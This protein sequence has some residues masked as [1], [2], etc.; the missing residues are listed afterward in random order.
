MAAP[1]ISNVT[2]VAASAI[3]ATQVLGLD[4]T[5]SVAIR[6]AMLVAYFPNL[7][8]REV[9]HDGTSFGPNYPAASGNSRTVISGG[10]R[11][12]LLRTG[13]WPA[14]PTIIPYVVDVAGE[15]NP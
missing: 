4:A 5:A 3:A 14:S 11:Y 12:T 10:F 2:P 9:I 7:G 6:L 1:V 8:I 15:E 13:G